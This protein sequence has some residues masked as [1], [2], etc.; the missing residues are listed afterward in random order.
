MLL[1]RFWCYYQMKKP[2]GSHNVGVMW[3]T[4]TVGV[5]S[6]RTCQNG[7][8]DPLGF[9]VCAYGWKGST[10]SEL[11]LPACLQ[12][13]NDTK[14]PSCSAPRVR[15]CHCVQQCI[16]AGAFKSHVPPHCFRR[17]SDLLSLSNV[18]S[19][20]ERLSG[21]ASTFR[22]RVEGHK[23]MFEPVDWDIGLR[24]RDQKQLR[25]VPS[26]RCRDHCK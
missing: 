2:S 16:E 6:M 24:H 10:C 21:E 13:D 3:I 9:C 18:P 11:A 1:Y 26:S 12:H 14:L 4:M 5:M 22:W 19:D 17:N 23:W 15:S 25:T 8:Y 7:H 20:I